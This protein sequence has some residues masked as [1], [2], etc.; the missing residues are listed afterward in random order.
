MHAIE[1][2]PCGIRYTSAATHDSFMLSPTQWNKNDIL[3]IDRAYIDYAK[4]EELTQRGVIYVTKMKKNLVY[5]T[6]SNVY[7]MNEKGEMVYNVKKVVFT[8]ELK[9]EEKIEH[10]ARIIS[11]VDI[12][13]KKIISLLTNDI[14]GNLQPED[15]IAIYKKRWAI[16]SLFKQLKQN[17]PLKYFYGES[18]NAIKIQI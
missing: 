6:K 1:G 4:F 7:M 13:K 16:E 11:Y 15:I 17:F 2:V 3:A 18:E 5:Q 10:K 12:D 8:K 14:D 9:N